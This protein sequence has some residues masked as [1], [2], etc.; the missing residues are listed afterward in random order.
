MKK[1]V[2]NDMLL[3][4]LLG[5]ILEGMKAESISNG[6]HDRGSNQNLKTYLELDRVL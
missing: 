2:S 6:F 4:L 3:L 5:E 1:K